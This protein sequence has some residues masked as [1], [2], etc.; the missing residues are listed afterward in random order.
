[1]QPRRTQRA[2]RGIGTIAAAIVATFCALSGELTRQLTAQQTPPASAQPIFRS[3]QQLVVE[4]VT[5]KD[6]DGRVVEGLTAKDFNVTEDG[7]PQTISFVEFQHVEPMVVAA[8][9]DQ[10]GTGSVPAPPPAPSP[11]IKSRRHRQA[12]RATAIAG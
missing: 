11:A 2:R 6:K 4:T 3:S 7:V 10:R 12:T 8:R 1:M 9:A 5:V